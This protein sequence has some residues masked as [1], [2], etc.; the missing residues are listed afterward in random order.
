MWRIYSSRNTEQLSTQNVQRHRSRRRRA[1]RGFIQKLFWTGPQS[2][3]QRR[4][5]IM[6]KKCKYSPSGPTRSPSLCSPRN[7]GHIGADSGRL[8]GE[9][10]MHQPAGRP[11]C[12]RGSCLF[13]DTCMLSVLCFI[14]AREV[15]SVARLP[16]AF[17]K[18]SF[19]SCNIITA[20]RNRTE[21]RSV[22]VL[23]E[24]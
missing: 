5:S 7:E 13:S 11:A 6:A 10:S 20:S 19:A 21:R 23:R 15:M 17:V 3:R 24:L 1:F 18:H 2:L 8:S 14:D 12:R 16:P 9:A 22:Q 4:K